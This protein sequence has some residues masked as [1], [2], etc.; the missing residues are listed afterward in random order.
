MRSWSGYATEPR[1]RYSPTRLGEIQAL[2]ERLAGARDRLRPDAAE[3]EGGT[4]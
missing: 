2:A 4:A 1:F 3:G